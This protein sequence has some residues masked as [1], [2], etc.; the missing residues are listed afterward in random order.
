M[1]TTHTH[2]KKSKGQFVH[3]I[4][5]ETE[6]L[7]DTTDCSTFPLTRSVVSSAQHSHIQVCVQPHL[8]AVNVTA[9]RICC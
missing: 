4:K 3:D 5:V 2:T 6:R 7:T 1:V 8:L 9:A